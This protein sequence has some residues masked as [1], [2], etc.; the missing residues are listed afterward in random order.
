MLQNALEFCRVYNEKANSEI[1]QTEGR[2]Q[3]NC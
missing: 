2:V 1:A 3:L